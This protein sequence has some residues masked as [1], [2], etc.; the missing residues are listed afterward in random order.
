[1]RF[2]ADLPFAKLILSSLNDLMINMIKLYMRDRLKTSAFFFFA[3]DCKVQARV[4]IT[5]VLEKHEPI[6]VKVTYGLG[7]GTTLE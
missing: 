1:M 7:F 5:N 2:G 4:Q 6:Y 3:Y